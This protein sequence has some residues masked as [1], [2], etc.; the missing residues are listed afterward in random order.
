MYMYINGEF[1]LETEAKISPFDHGFLY[2]LGVFE[3]FRIYDG[4]SFLLNDHFQRLEHSVKQLNIILKLSREE[5]TSIMSELL[6]LNQLKDAYVRLN[7]SAGEAPIGLQTEAYTSPTI[8]IF[9]KPINEPLPKVKQA[10]LL[11]TPRNTPEGAERLKSHHYLNSIL[12]KREVPDIGHE[13]IFL[14]KDGHIAEGVVSNVFWVKNGQVYTPSISTGILNG[15]TR[16]FIIELL[17]KNKLSCFEGLYFKEDLYSADEVFI[18][19]SIQEIVSIKAVDSC[20][21]KSDKK[22]TTQL[23]FLYEKYKNKQ[24][25]AIKEMNERT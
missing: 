23:Q 9:M 11:K 2:G 4:H 24:L 7:V 16:K 22:V 1:V 5:L 18:T 15:I 20:E 12:G 17:K 10:M 25:S 19:N 21:Y 13:G 14:T 6:L 3:T 8:L